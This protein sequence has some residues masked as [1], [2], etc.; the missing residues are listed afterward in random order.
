MKKHCER[1]FDEFLTITIITITISIQLEIYAPNNNGTRA[2][3]KLSPN[4]K[5]CQHKMGV[6]N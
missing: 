2:V 6:S 3:E 5:S 1:P 4:K